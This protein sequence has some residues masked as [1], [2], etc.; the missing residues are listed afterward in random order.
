MTRGGKRPGAGRPINKDP[1]KHTVRLT[2]SE[3]D[4]I[5]LNERPDLYIQAI[6]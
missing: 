2:D 6:I 1:K 4:F 3:K 5:D